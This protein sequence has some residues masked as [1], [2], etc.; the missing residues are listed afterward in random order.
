M[1]RQLRWLKHIEQHMRLPLGREIWVWF[2]IMPIPQRSRDL[3]ILAI[4]SLCCYTQL[5]TR[6]VRPF[7]SP[8]CLCV[9]RV[10]RDRERDPTAS[11]LAV[12]LYRSCA[13]RTRG[14]R[15]TASRTRTTRYRRARCKSILSA[16]GAVWKYWRLSRRSNF[17]AATG[18]PA[19]GIFASDIC[20]ECL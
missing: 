19:R 12:G 20:K 11:S 8:R 6:S 14:P 10:T 9:R 2:D 17:C 3:Q 5:C 15:P 13:M 16:D 4:G 1:S 18:A 7:A